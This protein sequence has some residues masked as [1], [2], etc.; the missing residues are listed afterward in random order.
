MQCSSLSG[1]A[2]CINITTENSLHCEL[3]REKAKKLY[4]K[5][6]QCQ[7]KCKDLD[8]SIKIEEHLLN[9]YI[10]L[11]EAYNTR[12]KHRKYHIVEEIQDKGHNYQFEKLQEQID[13]CEKHLFE[14]NDN[15]GN[16]I[17]EI[18]EKLKENKEEIIIRKITEKRQYRKVIKDDYEELLS[19]YIEENNK[20]KEEKIKVLKLLI[21]SLLSL[22]LFNRNGR[23]YFCFEQYDIVILPFNNDERIP[24]IV[25]DVPGKCIYEIMLSIFQFIYKLNNINYFTLNTEYNSHRII[26][27]LK[28]LG[29]ID[30][31]FDNFSLEIVKKVYESTLLY[32]SKIE[33]LIRELIYNRIIHKN[34]STFLLYRD[35]ANSEFVLYGLDKNL[36]THTYDINNKL[37]EKVIMKIE[38]Y[39]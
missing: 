11:N 16:K 21:K 18:N 27:P 9:C 19:S 29:D 13:L 23:R 14:L 39:K 8:L 36:V 15:K 20:Y 12:I 32:R 30:D 34:L 24:T 2:R 22:F 6:K 17:N 38:D 10:L 5:Y 31:F 28:L 37:K 33:K 3:H 4:L 7:D 25:H 1:K 35:D 26:L